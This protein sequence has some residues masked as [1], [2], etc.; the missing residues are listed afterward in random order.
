[1]TQSLYLFILQLNTEGILMACLVLKVV[2]GELCELVTRR[3]LSGMY[4]EER[5][6]PDA[7]PLRRVGL[8]LHK[9]V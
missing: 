8:S 6:C 3:T 9:W 2:L 5:L 1:M 4:I 7:G